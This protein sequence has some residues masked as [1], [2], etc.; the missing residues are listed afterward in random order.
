[1]ELI[2]VLIQICKT[3]KEMWTDRMF[4][5]IK[6]LLLKILDVTMIVQV[7]FKGIFVL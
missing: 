5:N 3:I 1:M 4:D 6:E 7:F 2:W